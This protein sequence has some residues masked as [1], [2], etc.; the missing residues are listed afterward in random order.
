V[1][2]W[3]DAHIS[4]GIAAWIKET[5]GIEA[6]SLRSLGL[7]ESNDYEIFLRAKSEEVVFITKDADFL[8]L[9]QAHG[10]PPNVILVCCG[11]TTNRRLR[12]IFANHLLSCLDRF[13]SGESIIE[14]Q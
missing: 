6:N 9:V 13:R 4:P 11:N 10:A 12:E 7:R 2:I 1:K 5:F 8:H 3:I 14:I